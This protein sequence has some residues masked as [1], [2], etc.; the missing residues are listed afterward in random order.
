MKK[1]HHMFFRVFFTWA[2]MMVSCPTPPGPGP[3]SSPLRI[4]LRP[5]IVHLGDVL[6]KE[7]AQTAKHHKNKNELFIF[8][9][10]PVNLLLELTLS[11]PK[12]SLPTVLKSMRGTDFLT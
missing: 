11:I 4:V 10:I 6:H 1:E 3:T 5:A 9:R 2:R 8:G 7:E 12:F